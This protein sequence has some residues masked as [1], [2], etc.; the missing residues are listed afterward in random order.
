MM[1]FKEMSMTNWQ[2]FWAW[3][4][5]LDGGSVFVGAILCIVLYAAGRILGWWR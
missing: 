1:F 5:N 3:L 2:R 4:E